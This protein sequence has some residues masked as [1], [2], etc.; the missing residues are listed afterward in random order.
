MLNSSSSNY[1]E[2]II[3]RSIIKVKISNSFQTNSK[4]QVSI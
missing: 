3:D 2:N 1:T 4:Y